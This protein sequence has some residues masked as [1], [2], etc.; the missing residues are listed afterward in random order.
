[1]SI[2]WVFTIILI[3]YDS[4]KDNFPINRIFDE[5]DGLTLQAVKAIE[6]NDLNQLGELMNIN[7][8]LLNALQVSSREL[9]D[10]IEISRRNGAVGA[11]LTGSGGG[12]AM[13]AICPDG[14]EKVAFAIRKSGYKALVTEIGKKE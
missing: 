10:L 5:I 12:G 3:K 2:K 11:K 9:E 6:K 14:A 4:N 7:Q 1:M 8:G 13:V